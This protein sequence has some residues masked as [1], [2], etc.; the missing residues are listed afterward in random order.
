MVETRSISETAEI[1]GTKAFEKKEHIKA[2]IIDF[3]AG[4]L[5]M[6]TLR[7]KKQFII[8]H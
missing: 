1:A 4:S 2:G 7:T 5:G 6:L 8:Q 3:V